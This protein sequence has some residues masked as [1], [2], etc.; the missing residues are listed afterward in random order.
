MHTHS[1][2]SFASPLQP[3]KLQGG[4]A[5]DTVIIL[6]PALS[7]QV[8]Y[9]SLVG[10]SY[11]FPSPSTSLTQPTTHFLEQQLP[12]IEVSPSTPDSVALP[13]KR[14][15]LAVSV[16]VKS[17]PED[18]TL[19]PS[20][21]EFVEQV[22]RPTIAA[23]E[24]GKADSSSDGESEE[25]GKVVEEEETPEKTDTPPISFPVDVT[26][27][28]H[29]QPSKVCFSCQP[30][31]RVHCIVCSPNVNFVVSFSLFSAR[32]V[33][34]AA[35]SPTQHSIVTFNNLY[36]T[37]CLETFTLQ[38]LSPQVSSLKYNESE[39]KTTDKEALSL[40][41]GQALVHLSR[42]SVLVPSRKSSPDAFCSQSKL[43]VSGKHL[44]G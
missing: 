1:A 38:V 16:V 13:M 15:I 31:S 44:S 27:V 11:Q 9:K 17:T 37:G 26:I 25:E 10:Q 18:M 42:K 7:V 43:Q 8:H 3:R 23:T 29:M 4:S 33:E 24:S 21:L 41:L 2:S 12:N 6:I 20:L 22:V 35:L 39:S 14:G 30:H 40:T 32:E 28:F 34:G 19:N 36:V 5:N